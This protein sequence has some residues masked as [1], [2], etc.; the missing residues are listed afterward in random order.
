ME[1]RDAVPDG[2][3]VTNFALW[4]EGIRCGLINLPHNRTPFAWRQCARLLLCPVD[5]WRYH[6]FRAVLSA[7]RGESNI[8]DIGSPKLLALYFARS[9]RAAVVSTDI[10]RGVDDECALYQ[11]ATPHGSIEPRQCDA[12]AL[13]F[14]DASIPFLYSV[15]VLE[16]IADDGDIRAVREI[17]RVLKPGGRA[18]ITVPLVPDYRE[19]WADAD[20]Y[21]EQQ[22]NAEGKVFF[23]RYYDWTALQERIIEPSGLTVR[24]VRVWQESRPGWYERYCARTANAMSPISILAKLLDPLWTSSRLRPVEERPPQVTGHGLVALILERPLV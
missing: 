18:V 24:D 13:P 8:L 19:R 9:H 15:S 12:R 10:V 2:T 3:P 16:H 7:Y 5:L 11:R 6:E 14:D 4:W 1:R 22:R 20:P 21:G 23:S 17:A